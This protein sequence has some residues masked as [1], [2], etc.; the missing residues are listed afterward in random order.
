MTDQKQN[1]AEPTV[2][3]RLGSVKIVAGLLEEGLPQL[4]QALPSHVDPERFVKVVLT[5]VHQNPKLLLCTR[6]SFFLAALQCAEL[7]L[8]PHLGQAYIIP[9]RNKRGKDWVHEATFQTGYRGLQILAMRS[10]RYERLEA[11]V[12]RE[13]DEFHY[14]FGLNPDLTH[15]PALTVEKQPLTHVYSIAWP[16][17]VDQRPGFEPMSREQVEAIRMKSKAKDDG[18]WVTDF[19]EMARKTVFNRHAKWLDLSPEVREVIERDNLA[20]TGGLLTTAASVLLRKASSMKEIVGAAA[21][22]DAEIKALPKPPTRTDEVR[23]ELEERLN[24]AEDP[25]S[26]LDSWCQLPKFRGRPWREVVDDPEGP[27]YINTHVLTAR[28]KHD[29]VTPELREVLTMA[30]ERK[31]N[32][33]EEEATPESPEPPEVPPEAAAGTLEEAHERAQTVAGHL[34]MAEQLTMQQSEEVELLF[35]DGNLQGLIDLT[36]ELE[37][38]L[39]A[40]GEEAGQAQGE[41]EPDL[42]QEG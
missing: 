19:D 3:T 38:K 15:V 32:N 6:G 23:A 31:A 25:P 5:V 22:V 20:D 37:A 34:A 11:R 12:V 8:E 13:G 28:C 9:Y 4:A 35:H 36:V 33:S 18:P 40:I 41:P 17:D 2:D 30:L 10:G 14:Q 24:G 27:H 16:K 42:F 29:S 21:E 26:L 39:E 1:G 7:G